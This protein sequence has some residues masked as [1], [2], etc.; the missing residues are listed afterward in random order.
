MVKRNYAFD[1]EFVVR[2]EPPTFPKSPKRFM[3]WS[4]EQILGTLP[5][6]QRGQ[7]PL[8]Q[9]CLEETPILRQRSQSPFAGVPKCSLYIA[10][11]RDKNRHGPTF[12]SFSP[13]AD[14]G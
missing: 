4:R 5:L 9:L 2:N 8:P 13:G 12:F 3:M 14:H 7:A 10:P 6:R 11:P 1:R